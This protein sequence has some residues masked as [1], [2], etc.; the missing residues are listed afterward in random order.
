[1]LNYFPEGILYL[2]PEQCSGHTGDH[3][4]DVYSFGCIMY[5]SLVG[6]PPFLSKSPY[7]VSRMQI[8]EEAKPLRM[9]RD[10]L[11]F[12][13]ELDLL[14]LKSLRKNPNQRQQNF[15]ELLEDLQHVQQELA[16]VPEMGR[17]EP[18]MRTIVSDILEDLGD[19]LGMDSS[20]KIKLSAFVIVG[21]LLIGGSIAVAYSLNG[22]QNQK[23]SDSA[24]EREWQQLDSQAQKY[25]EKGNISAAESTY[26]KALGIAEKFGDKDRRLLVTLRNLQDIYFSQKRSDKADEV[27]ARIKS[28]MAEESP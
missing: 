8:A 14:V 19:L 3:R 11:N 20:T 9:S 22:W 24:A 13:L 25:Y 16:K 6:L 4:S 23:G 17:T 12:P 21:L 18:R 26:N 2:S 28:I 15:T 7:E 10:D 5:E 1:M 27:E